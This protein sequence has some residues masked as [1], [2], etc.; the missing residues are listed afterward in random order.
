MESKCAERS[1]TSSSDVE[2]SLERKSARLPVLT[3]AGAVSEYT[4]F[5]MGPWS[6]ILGSDGNVWFPDGGDGSILTQRYIGR[7]TPGGSV[8]EFLTNGLPNSLL[9]SPDGGSLIYFGENAPLLG[10]VAVG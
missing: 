6:P 10:S 9:N 1:R 8:S 2:V 4:T 5:G 3:P 7:V